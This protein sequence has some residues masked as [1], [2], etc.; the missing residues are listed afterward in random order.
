MLEDGGV[1][2]QVGLV[3]TNQFPR[4]VCHIIDCLL[5]VQKGGNEVNTRCESSNIGYALDTK[6]NATDVQ[7][8]MP[9]LAKRAE[10]LSPERRNT[11]GI[12]ELLQ[13]LNFHLCQQI[14][15]DGGPMEERRKLM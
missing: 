4:D 14:T 9:I 15:L 3:Q 11:G 13:Q 2:V 7:K 12:I 8:D 1:C 6:V 5:C 10:P